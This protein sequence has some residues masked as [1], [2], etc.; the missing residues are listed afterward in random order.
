MLDSNTLDILK[1]TSKFYFP[2]E[3]YQVF[4]FGS[5]AK[6]TNQKFSDI[7]IGIIPKKTL[8]IDKKNAFQSCL[9][10]S[11]IPYLIDIV[12]FNTVSKQFKKNAIKKII[13]INE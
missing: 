9:E 11:E 10:N 12:D 1:K 3:E 6:G 13:N 5:W 2:K 8:N 4:I 7:D